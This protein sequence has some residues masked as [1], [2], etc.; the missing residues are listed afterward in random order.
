MTDRKLYPLTEDLVKTKDI[1]VRT[2]NCCIKTGLESL[3][4]I[5][6]Y[7]GNGESFRNIE[8]AG[9]KTFLELQWL[10]ETLTSTI[11][12]RTLP[13]LEE[14]SVQDESEMT[15]RFNALLL[16]DF[17][18]KSIENK[19]EQIIQTCSVSVR[20]WLEHVPLITFVSEYLTGPGNNNPPAE[21]FY[22]RNMRE[23]IDLKEKLK[24]EI[25]RQFY[26]SKEE[27]LKE[28]IYNHYGLT[29]CSAEYPVSYYLKYGHFPMF[30]IL[31]K[32]L[33]NDSERDVNALKET[34]R[35]YRNQKTI[36][37][38]EFAAK[39][40]ISRE[41]VRQI[42]KE[43]FG[44]IFRY[45]SIFFQDKNWQL[46]EPCSKDAIWQEDM[47]F[48][49]NE[50]QCNFS[51][52]FILQILLIILYYDN[53]T[54]FGGLDSKLT[55]NSWH[56]TFLVKN[57]IVEIF[58]FDKFKLEFNAIQLGNKSEYL[59]DIQT[60]VAKSK[61]W[62]KSV[63]E[64]RANIADIVK[65]IL[66]LEFQI[67]PDMDGRIK[68]SA[69]K[70][71]TM[72][73]KV[74]DILKNNGNP[75]HLSEVFAEFKRINPE[76][77]YSDPVQLRPS[78]LKHESISYRNRKS[79]Y[80][81][82]EWTHVKFGTIRS[83]IIEFLSK[84]KSPQSSK[85][86]T[87]YVLQYFPE[88]NTASV[89]TS[90]FNDTQHRFVFFN[91]EFFGLAYKKYHPKYE[92]TENSLMPFAQRVSCLEKFIVENEHFP[93]A[94]SK[95]RDERILGVWWV[96]VS[97]GVYIIDEGQQKEIKRVKTQYA[98]YD[99]NKRAFQWNK[100]YRKIKSFILENHKLPSI[101]SERFL[102]HWYGRLK[103]D[104]LEN[105]LNEKQRQKYIELT[106][107]IDATE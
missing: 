98:N 72:S 22:T 70:R 102:Y 62:K 57:E 63:P 48:Y 54:L 100:N 69:Y 23:A 4:D 26:M 65:E 6:I 97:K 56:N 17:K 29:G 73:D 1:S 77:Y 52:E 34:F 75:M 41:R 21:H 64:A 37:L 36:S 82:K 19:Y 67:Y 33:E 91:N 88:T 78:L 86:I 92:R 66:R 83:C 50:E 61:C 49:I 71:K 90:M 84:K 103:T 58:D 16:D 96:R 51:E 10:C 24:T 2:A 94:S 7:Y 68:I 3:Y 104:F 87:D 14:V 53:Y 79:I 95:N 8:G 15:E 46:Y 80:L 43:V 60:L 42:R 39:Y 12:N 31:E 38:N 28:E 27:Y 32:Q 99:S 107:L 25:T 11:P 9:P 30:W 85:D 55:K 105:N 18:K 106:E 81:L 13:K 76:H 47:Q 59:Q 40:S 93:F 35:I 20:I 5:L 45:K 74:Y 101:S 44:E 89:R